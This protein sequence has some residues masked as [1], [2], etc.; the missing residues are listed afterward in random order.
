MRIA[1][2]TLSVVAGLVTPAGS[3]TP[4]PRGEL[5]EGIVCT[6]DP[7]QT[8]TLYL[9]PEYD[10]ERKWPVMLV[11]DPRGR[12]VMAAELFRDAAEEYGW[13]LVS[14]NDTRSDGPMDPNR[15][16][17]NAMWQDLQTR[18]A[19]DAKRI[20][21]AG[22][23][24]TA[25]VSYLVG[26][27]TGILAGVIAA[28]GRFSE[29]PLMD[30]T[31]A[32]FGAVGS[33]DFNYDDMRLVDDF[34]GKQG[35]HHRLE[36]FD[37]S[38]Q[39]MPAPIARQAVEWMELDAMRKGHRPKDKAL[40]SRIYQQDLAAAEALESAGNALAALRRYQAVVTTFEGL[41]DI[42]E[43]VQRAERLAAGQEVK[44]ARKDETKWDKY[45]ARYQD[46]A[47]GI[48]TDF[49]TAEVPSSVTKLA[50]DLRIEELQRR[51]AKEGYEAVTAQRILNRTYTRASFYMTRELIQNQK[52]SHAAV[53]LE[54]AT[55]IRDDNPV[56]WYNLAC[57]RARVGREQAAVDALERSVAGG[58]TDVEYFEGDAD[59]ESI[60]GLDR[61]Q[62]LI[63]GLRAD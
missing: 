47:F 26:Q 24:G 23:S 1:I 31:F 14:S 59:L 62:E 52:Y 35:N 21:A 43:P 30:T 10:H 19:T 58:F 5:V 13:V 49:R 33:T 61:Y 3:E 20:Y 9:P 12:S 11:L 45:E 8:Y 53:V 18:Y 41:H 50:R 32:H 6:Q 48:M 56:D 63:E 28:G 55:T 4:H 57:A 46:R 16:A 60:R 42:V 22:F 37:G 54:L 36:I 39:W 29:L 34:L 7:T 2:L 51:A 25:F 27:Q 44:Q 15:R 38:H 40:I 17:V